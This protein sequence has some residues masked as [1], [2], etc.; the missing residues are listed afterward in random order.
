MINYTT[1]NPSPIDSFLVTFNDAAVTLNLCGGK[2]SNLAKLYKSGYP[3]PPGFILTTRAYAEFT[4]IHNLDQW[5]QSELRKTP[6]DQFHTL[7]ELSLKIRF[8]FGQE[9]IP[10]EI[11]RLLLQTYRDLGLQAVAVRSSATTEDLPELSFAGQQDT[12]LNIVGEQALLRAVIDC[13]SSLWTARAI[14]YR[15]RNHLSQEKL[16]L[17]VVVQ[18]MLPSEVSGVLFTANP[19]TGRR[20]EAV[21]DA[22]LGLGEGLVSGQVVPDQYIVD[23][24]AEKIIQKQLGEKAVSIRLNPEG[25]VRQVRETAAGRQALPDAEILTLARLGSRVEAE[26]GCPQDIEWGW[27]NGQ[28]A[29]LQSRPITS[30]YPLPEDLPERPLKVLLSFGAF[31]GM[32]DPITPAG[33]SALGEVIA[34]GARLFGY[35]LTPQTQTLLF[36]A[37]ERLWVNFTPIF[38]NTLGR[39]VLGSALPMVEPAAGAI[40]SKLTNDPELLPGSP[41]VSIKARIRL[42]KFLVPLIFNVLNNLAFPEARRKYIVGRGERILE[43][44]KD[45]ARQINGDRHEKLRQR[46]RLLPDIC[47]IELPATFLA[48][49]SGVASGVA[50]LN[51]VSMLTRSHLTGSEA[52]GDR[53]W[54]QEV[55]ELT[56]GIPNNPTT[57]MDL[58]LW[59]V[60]KDFREDPEMAECFSRQS[61]QQIAHS[62]LAG[63]LPPQGQAAIRNFLDQYGGRGLAEIDLGRIRWSEDP[64]HVIQV[65]GSYMQITN[66]EMAPDVVFQ[67]SA[68]TAQE[69]KNRLLRKVRGTR[70]GWLKARLVDFFASR[71]RALMGLRENP[72]FFAVRMLDLIRSQL[73]LSGEEFVQCGE[74]EQRDDFLYLTFTELES[75]AARETRDWREIIRQ[76][77]ESYQRELLRRQ[78][79]RI[80]LSDGRAFYEGVQ[81]VDAGE[82]VVVG[83]PVSPGTVEG[84]IRVVF[85]PSKSQ[86]Q[87]GE[88]LVCP[89]TDPS[90]TP[91]F[92]AAGGLIMEV[93]GMMT[94]GAVVAREYGIPAVVGVH[95]ATS[96][97]QNGQRVRLDGSKGIIQCMDEMNK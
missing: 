75:F 3:I 76:R 46:V 81:A 26:F 7:E 54:H 27:M 20:K 8:R 82:G 79:P 22:T 55:L 84:M 23:T 33:R 1:F 41:G 49:V 85:D 72:K 56:R 15:A 48:F 37:G 17:A 34:G 32:L 69:A 29:L 11:A 57:S 30:L 5:I 74:I 90:W 62:Y 60:A 63:S 52:K 87:P 35:R 42:A 36:T 16:A 51:F 18:A 86:L 97:F 67:R 89:G 66:P 21:I 40:F 70:Y 94:H 64:L 61:P 88:I 28:L 19:L 2:G 92:L 6:L 96:R 83:S 77:R 10:D 39:K 58:A 38:R 59:K 9:T 68:Q 45:L 73:L 80:L 47:A 13:W 50:S 25:G 91:L 24:A 14:G 12:Y 78:I 65:I 53:I 44:V 4:R 43:Q 95:Q 93:G 31:Q 71:V